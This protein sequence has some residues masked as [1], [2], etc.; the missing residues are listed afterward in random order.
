MLAL[1]MRIDA[2]QMFCNCRLYLRS[3]FLVDSLEPFLATG[4]NFVLFMSKH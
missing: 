3:I 4:A 1:E 2:F